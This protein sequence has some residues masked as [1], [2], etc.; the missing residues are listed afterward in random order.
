[1]HIFIALCSKTL[2]THKGEN[3]EK[4]RMFYYVKDKCTNPT[5]VY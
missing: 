3:P 2:D 1:M 5:L 4:L